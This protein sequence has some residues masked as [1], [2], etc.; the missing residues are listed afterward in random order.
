[1]TEIDKV[2]IIGLDAADPV[3]AFDQWLDDLPHLK[4]LTEQGLWGPL[5]S[6]VPPVTVPAWAC[7]A[8]SKDPGSLGIYG[9][10]NRRDWSYEEPGLATNLEVRH[11]RLWDH[12][13]RAGLSSILLGIPQTFPIVR[14][15][16]GTLVTGFLTPSTDSP[17]TH[18]PELAEEIRG[19]VGHYLLDVPN[20][21]TDDKQSL[22]DQLR[23]MTEQR[24]EVARRLATARKWS[25]F[26]MVDMGIDRVQHG[27]WQYMD[28]QHRLYDDASYF[29]DAIHEYYVLVDREL[30][31][32]L[33]CFDRKS[34][35]VLVVSDHGAKRL[36]GGFCIN[37]WL[38][39]EGLLTMKTP[40][41]G[42]RRF[43]LRDVD[44][45]QTHVWS[46]GGYFAR[47][48]I[49]R[50]GREPQGIVPPLRYEALRDEL[51]EKLEALPGPDGPA[52]RNRV[53]RPESI[54]EAIKGVP[55]DLVALVGDLHYRS[56][57]RIGQAE[58]ITSDPGVGP[59]GA[60]HAL[61]GLYVAAH[62]ALPQDHRP[63]SLYDI[64]PT[65]LELLG[66]PLP[67]GLCGRSL[68][69]G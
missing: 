37:D 28:P 59:D 45:S 21:R 29:K 19:W 49:N 27:F 8:T 31:R 18:P 38:M 54:Y 58:L 39:R 32:L 13:A 68:L 14:P 36:D 23:R 9:F 22:L 66:L 35:A 34:T 46:E 26:W 67:R 7:M 12:I 55:P 42:P 69:V 60:N 1:M 6:C 30:G 2:A 61:H 44:W 52:L 47:L 53:Y 24:F 64:A 25:L 43:E 48:Y 63:A 65:V 56:V 41:D 50:A 40:V 33:D 11:P 4:Q 51:I 15:P 62:P 17:Y 3:L 5:E 57:G 20:F 16:K 10:M